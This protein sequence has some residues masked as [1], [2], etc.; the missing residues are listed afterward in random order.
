MRMHSHKQVLIYK[1]RKNCTKSVFSEVTMSVNIAF[2][3]SETDSESDDFSV[4]SPS[5][6]TV[7]E[8]ED[9]GKEPAADLESFIP[10]TYVD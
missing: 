3:Y 5:Q 8:G 2:I 4:Q 7:D 6:R 1:I 10:S 9:E